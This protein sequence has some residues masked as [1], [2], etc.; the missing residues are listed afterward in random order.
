MFSNV[1]LSGRFHRATEARTQPVQHRGAAPPDEMKGGI[2]KTMP[3]QSEPD[4]AFWTRTLR[5]RS[6]C[7]KGHRERT[8]SPEESRHDGRL[9]Q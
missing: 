6:A 2:C 5:C 4:R 8:L 9:W 1:V 7:V 3:A